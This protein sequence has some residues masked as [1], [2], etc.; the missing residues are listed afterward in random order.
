MTPCPP[1]LST[2]S[3]QS[4]RDHR[5]MHVPFVA[6]TRVMRVL[7]VDD[8]PG[9][10]TSVAAALRR[11]GCSV[12]LACDGTEALDRLASGKFDSVV[13]DVLM[14]GLD[15][16]AACRQLRARGDLTPILMLT[17][18]NLVADRVGGSRRRCGRLPDQAVA[19]EEAARPAA[20]TA[21]AYHAR[22][23]SGR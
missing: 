11:D 13:L 1:R 15:G 14:P 21:A 20:R 18:R 9:V 6:D 22:G 4:A 2:C 12:E 17:A 8:D 5:L 23:R 16:L 7:V 10:R 19:L 3:C